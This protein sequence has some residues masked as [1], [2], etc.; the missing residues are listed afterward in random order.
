MAARFVSFALGAIVVA[1]G[2]QNYRVIAQAISAGLN[3]G[4][5]LLIVVSAGIVGVAKVYIASEVV[6]MLGYLFLV[7]L[8]QH[9]E[10]RRACS[11]PHQPAKS[12]S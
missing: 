3:V 1:V 11:R 4:L 10:K 9:R 7:L 12:E 8:W 5:N 2:W 6:L